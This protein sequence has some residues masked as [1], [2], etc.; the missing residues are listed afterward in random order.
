M[1]IFR[2]AFRRWLATDNELAPCGR[3]GHPSQIEHIGITEAGNG[4]VIV[5]HPLNYDDKPVMY[6]SH[7]V[8]GLCD[9]LTLALVNRKIAETR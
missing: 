7:D 3:S 4:Y 8:E 6:V 9:T 1:G 5:V 2:E